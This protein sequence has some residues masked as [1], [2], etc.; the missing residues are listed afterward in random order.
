MIWKPKP[1][2]I[3][4]CVTEEELAAENPPTFAELFDEFLEKHNLSGVRKKNFRVVKRALM[5]Y[6]RRSCQREYNDI[7]R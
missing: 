4:A 6:E 5:R 7:L 2:S 1:P 3:S